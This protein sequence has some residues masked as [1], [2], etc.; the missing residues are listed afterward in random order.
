M[1]IRQSTRVVEDISGGMQRFCM[2]CMHKVD[3]SYKYIVQRRDVVVVVTVGIVVVVVVEGDSC[4]KKEGSAAAELNRRGCV[5]EGSEAD[6]AT[7]CS[8][9][10][11]SLVSHC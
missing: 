10:V 8:R 2:H 6:R 1:M 9:T 7:K 11:M 5:Q 3:K 4:M